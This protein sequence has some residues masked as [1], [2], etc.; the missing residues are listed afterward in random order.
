MSANCTFSD[1]DNVTMVLDFVIYVPV[2]VFGLALNITALVV[3]CVL[4]R[5]WT[6]STIYMTNLALM[7]LLLLL[8]LPFKMHAAMHTWASNTK[9]FCSFLES[10]YFVGM[11]GSIY[12]IACIAV[13]RYIAIKYPFRAKQLRS[14]KVAL[15]VCGFI[16]VFVMGATSPIYTF[17]DENNDDFRC[18]HGFSKKGWT[19]GVIVCLEIFGFLL[20]AT[21]LVVCSTQSIRTLKATESKNSKRQAGVRIIYSSLAAFLIPFTPCHA[22]IFLQYLVRNDFISDCSQQKNIA[23]FIQV[24]MSLAN[25][26]ICLDALCYYFIAKEVRS[27]TDTVLSRVRSISTSEV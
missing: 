3:F 17:R 20:P 1:V 13:D 15:I 5:K 18:F 19:T 11:Y 23:V 9:F 10:L 12:T 14:K 2:L 25:V 8:P 27:T 7:D 26:T 21:V 4:L 16:W 22:A 6:E 24:S